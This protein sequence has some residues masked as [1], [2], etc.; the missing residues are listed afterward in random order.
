MNVYTLRPDS[1]H[2]QAI[3]LETDEA[4]DPFLDRFD[5]RAIGGAWWHPRIEILREVPR[6]YDLLP[7][8]FPSLGGIIPVFSQKAVSALRDLLEENG[9]LLPLVCDEGEYFAYNVT[10]IVDALDEKQSSVDRFATGN[11]MGISRYHLQSTALDSLTI[12]KLPQSAR[13]ET[14]VTD[15]FVDRASKGGLVGFDFQRIWPPSSR[16]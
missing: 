13:V 15:T 9:E 2:Y 1:D 8:D 6:D 10:R 3:E 5:G 4:W 16:E 7:G 12:F 11:I 14:Y